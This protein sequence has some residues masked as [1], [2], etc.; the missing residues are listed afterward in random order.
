MHLLPAS[1]PSPVVASTLL[2]EALSIGQ[3]AMRVG[4][5]SGSVF[6]GWLLLDLFGSALRTGTIPISYRSRDTSLT[7]L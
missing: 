1:P 7:S 5:S 2:C 6:G 3:V 4:A